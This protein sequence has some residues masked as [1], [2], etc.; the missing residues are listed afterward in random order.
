M[1][2]QF[3]GILQGLLF[4]LRPLAKQTTT[5][6]DDLLVTILDAALSN[7]LQAQAALQVAHASLQ[8]QAQAAAAVSAPAAAPKV[9]EDKGAGKR[10][11]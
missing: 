11:G 7:P 3:R 8:Q 10:G 5:T 6:L 2:P 4:L 9:T 1:S